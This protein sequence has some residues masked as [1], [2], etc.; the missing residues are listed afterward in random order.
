MSLVG[1]ACVWSASTFTSAPRLLTAAPLARGASIVSD[2]AHELRAIGVQLE[3]LDL[4]GGLGIAYEP[5]QTVVSP[6]AYAS[7]L[8]PIVS[9]TGLTLVLEPGRWIVGPSGVLLT[10]VVDL[11]PRPDGGAFV[12]VDAG[13]TDL[14]RPAFLRRLARH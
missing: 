12:I 14:M 10:E 6:E 8:I 3:H 5:G 13:M 2:L 7:A 11:K 9:R 4:G 1:R